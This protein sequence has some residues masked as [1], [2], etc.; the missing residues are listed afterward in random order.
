MAEDTKQHEDAASQNPASVLAPKRMTGPRRG[1]P[2]RWSR[3]GR[4]AD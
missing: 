1:T 4:I 3:C 2:F